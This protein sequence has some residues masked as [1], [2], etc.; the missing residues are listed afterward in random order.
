MPL[1]GVGRWRRKPMTISSGFDS[2]LRPAYHVR[3]IRKWF[4]SV[5]CVVGGRVVWV[6]GPMGSCAHLKCN[7]ERLPV[8]HSGPGSLQMRR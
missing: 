4:F 1:V 7:A 2:C 5:W 6:V 3:H 8:A